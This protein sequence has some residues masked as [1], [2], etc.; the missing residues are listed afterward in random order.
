MK[1]VHKLAVTTVGIALS[2][3]I[4]EP[5]PVKAATI[6]YDFTVDVTSGQLSGNQ[7]SGFFSYD[8][9]SPSSSSRLLF[10]V[11]DETEFNFE[12]AGR[13]YT[14]RDLRSGC[15]GLPCGSL[16]IPGVKLLSDRL[17]R[18]LLLS[19]EGVAY[20][21][22]VSPLSIGSTFALVLSR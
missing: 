11:F 5:R 3:T 6:T 12:F 17:V 19:P 9:S 20:H 8:D 18:L 15:R 2:F 14:R 21:F 13:T 7:Y 10:S 22:L 1:F 4:M 16:Q